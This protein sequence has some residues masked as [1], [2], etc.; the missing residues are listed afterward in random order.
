MTDVWDPRHAPLTP[1][2]LAEVWLDHG[3]A[4]LTPH[5]FADLAAAIVEAVRRAEQR[6]RVPDGAGIPDDEAERAGVLP[7]DLDPF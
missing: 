7:D 4:Q 5:R 6:E 1:N 3:Y 2:E